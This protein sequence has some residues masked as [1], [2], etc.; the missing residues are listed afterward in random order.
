MSGTVSNNISQSSGSITEPAGGVSIVSSDPTLTTGL[1][2]YN[3]TSNVLKVARN[4]TAWSSGGDLNTGRQSATGTNGTQSA[5][6]V[7]GAIN[8]S[9]SRLVSSE[10]YDGSAWSNTGDL[11][12][13]GREGGSSWGTVA[14]GAVAGGWTGSLATLTNEFN[15]TSWADASAALAAG[16]Y[17]HGSC[18]T[19]TAGLSR[20]GGYNNV[21]R[22]NT[23]EEYDGS[24]HSSGGNLSG[25]RGTAV[26]CG[27][28]TSAV[29]AGG[30]SAG[31]AGNILTIC[32]TYN[33][34]AWTTSGATIASKK[35]QAGIFGASDSDATLAGGNDNSVD[36][37]TA[38]SWNGTSWSSIDSLP[39]IKANVGAGGNSSGT[40]LI[41]GGSNYEGDTDETTEYGTALTAR[42]LSNS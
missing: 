6:F 16:S 20:I 18:G 3:S 34:T 39:A 37:A 11:T 1:L 30:Q 10:T 21:A 4:I 40:G 19:Q 22:I 25:L 33:G 23:C 32:E 26:T 8:P 35:R 12:G 7:A 29:Q 27:T 31:G 9:S 14:A 15:G 5:C 17:L 24:S 41:T 36:L 2:W 13:S 28:L 38:E 42:T